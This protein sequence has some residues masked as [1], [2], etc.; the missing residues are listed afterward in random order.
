[1]GVET[2]ADQGLKTLRRWSRPT[3]NHRAIDLVRGLDLYTCFNLL[4]F[5]PDTTLASLE[6]NIAFMRHAGENPFNFGRVE[7][8][9]GTPLLARMR[10][11]NRCWGDYLEWDYALGDP[12]VER[13]FS[14]AMRC[15]HARNFGERALA[16]DIMGTRFDIEVARHF[17]GDRFNPSWLAEGKALSRALASDTAGGLEAIIN[18]VKDRRDSDERF[19]SQL[20]DRLR[21]TERAIRQRMGTLASAVQEVVGGIPLT[22]IGDRVATPLQQAREVRL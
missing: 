2:D 13:V 16:N 3:H 17:H 7:L 19:V 20:S 8:Y 11:E 10:S 14:L 4:I 6:T 9:A 15:F 21:A 12:D 1:V 18:H 22:D 5:D